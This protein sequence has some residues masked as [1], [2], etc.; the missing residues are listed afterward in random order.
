M[1]LLMDSITN[2]YEPWNFNRA[3]HR[4]LFITEEI[5]QKSEECLAWKLKVQTKP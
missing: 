3:V 1:L 4:G 5:K 2:P